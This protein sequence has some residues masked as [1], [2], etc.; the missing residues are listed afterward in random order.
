MSSRMSKF[1][2]AAERFLEARRSG[3]S[4]A[5]Y[6]ELRRRYPKIYRHLSKLKDKSRV[7][8]TN[9]KKL[10]DKDIMEYVKYRKEKGLKM[11]SIQNDLSAIKK[12]CLFSS[13]NNCVD[14][15]RANSP[16][17]FMRKRQSRLPIVEKPQFEDIIRYINSI[18]PYSSRYLI[19]SAAAVALVFGSGA[20]SSEL[21][22]AKR[23]NL[24]LEHKCILYET[25][26]GG[27][28]YGEARTVPIRPEVIPMLKLYL[29]TTKSDSE[30]L[31]PNRNTGKP[32]S[33]ASIQA[34][35]KYIIE[36][37]GVK[38]DFR[39]ARRTY[40]QY[41]VDEGIPL[42]K[43]AVVMGH[44]IPSTTYRFYGG[45]RPDRVVREIARMW[46]KKENGDGS[47]H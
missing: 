12:I 22:N 16:T 17:L 44:S 30:Y 15:A 37:S 13:E 9:P 8:T 42:E 11:T 39:M 36:G 31:F 27:D 21:A 34:G 35:K 43:V 20:R 6:K 2:D 32:L 38:F 14:A 41:L 45:P 47:E 23:Q 26:K 28:T 19:R 1:M 25:V 5:M 7:S 46:E 29:D 24:D 18:P 10:T 3:Y 4:D 40:A 33:T